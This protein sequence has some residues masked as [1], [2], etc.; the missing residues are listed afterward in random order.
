[1]DISGTEPFKFPGVGSL[2]HSQKAT[3]S[4][5]TSVGGLL[6]LKTPDASCHR[7][8]YSLTMAAILRCRLPV[9]D[10]PLAFGIKSNATT[11]YNS[12]VEAP[13][14]LSQLPASGGHDN[15]CADAGS[16]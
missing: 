14:L 2:G 6:D 5:F 12:G 16:P 9:F 13:F 1:M 11:F 10:R 3:F 7:I 4:D 15:A 8:T